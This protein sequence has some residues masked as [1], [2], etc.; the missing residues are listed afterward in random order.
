MNTIFAIIAFLL[1]LYMLVLIARLV[2]DWI[3]VFARTW[4]P[5]GLVLV[6]ANGVY[7]LTDPP[8]RALR[9]LIPPLRLGQISIDL[10]FLV[11]FLAVSVLRGVFAG[12]S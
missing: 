6:L 3:Q 11:L 10:G 9:R 5:T 8:L 7:A 4:R 1:L 2:F 12:L